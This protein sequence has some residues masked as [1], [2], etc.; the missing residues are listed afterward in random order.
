MIRS[1]LFPAVALLLA[2][3]AAIAAPAGADPV[4]AEALYE[5]D[6]TRCHGPEVYTRED[7]RV[8]SFEAL[9]QQVRMCEQNLDLTW[10]DDQVDAVT[11]L[12]NREYYGF[13]R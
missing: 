7:R 11:E 12:L 2:P 4:D 9:H 6:C 3:A 5:Q 13:D 8:D 10:F 1:F